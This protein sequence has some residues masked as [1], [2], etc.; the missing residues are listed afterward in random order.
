MVR[1]YT[2]WRRDLRAAG[3]DNRESEQFHFS[4]L[5]ERSKPPYDQIAKVNFAPQLARGG[6]YGDGVYFASHAIYPVAY[7]QGW[8]HPT[9]SGGDATIPTDSEETISLVWAR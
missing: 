1:R 7:G 6:E 3:R 4:P 8:M 2:S 5:G 9:M